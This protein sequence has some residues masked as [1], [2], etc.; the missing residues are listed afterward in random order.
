M[1]DTMVSV[2]ETMVFAN[3][4]VFFAAAAMLFVKGKIFSL[5]LTT[6]FAN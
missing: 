4:K 2:Y 6:F 1:T 5:S 3:K